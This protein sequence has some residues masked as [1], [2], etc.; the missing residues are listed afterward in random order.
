M[1]VGQ[2]VCSHRIECLFFIFFRHSAVAV[3]KK[4]LNRPQR[5]LVGDQLYTQNLCCCLAGNVV[6]RRADAAGHDDGI[7][8]L[9]RLAQSRSDGIAVGNGR[10]PLN[11]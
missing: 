2:D 6:T 3:G 5:C 9:H 1:R 7:A 10:L 11:P 4:C 8:T